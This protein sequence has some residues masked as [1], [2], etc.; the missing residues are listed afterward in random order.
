MRDTHGLA[1]D[2][3]KQIEEIAEVLVEKKAMI[4]RSCNRCENYKNIK[5][6]EVKC[7]HREIQT[8]EEVIDEC[9]ASP[10]TTI[11]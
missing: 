6:V 1:K 8:D 5:D 3:S 7:E 2:L 4:G 11:V 10:A 9:I